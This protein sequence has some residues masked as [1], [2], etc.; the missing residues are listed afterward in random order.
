MNFLDNTQKKDL[1]LTDEEIKESPKLILRQEISKR[2]KKFMK[3]I[4]KLLFQCMSNT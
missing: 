4:R 1:G 2:F 3:L